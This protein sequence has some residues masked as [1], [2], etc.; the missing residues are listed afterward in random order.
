M[1]FE[2]NDVGIPPI[3]NPGPPPFGHLLLGEPRSRSPLSSVPGFDVLNIR[4]APLGVYP[5][6]VAFAC[7][8]T[9]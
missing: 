2:N 6:N 4:A 1:Q 8:D 7:I 9:K 5:P 3:P